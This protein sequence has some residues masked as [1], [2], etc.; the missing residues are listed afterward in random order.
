MT[1]Q[2]RDTELN[3][4]ILLLGAKSLDAFLSNKACDVD[5][6]HCFKCIATYGASISRNLSSNISNVRA[7]CIL[8]SGST[9]TFQALTRPY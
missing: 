5:I 9:S 3:K 2:S 8:S 6:I 7:N 1:G 4:R